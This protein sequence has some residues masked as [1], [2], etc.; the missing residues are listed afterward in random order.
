MYKLSRAK[1]KY[2]LKSIGIHKK[3]YLYRIYS[4]ISLWAMDSRLED[5][6]SHENL[7]GR[8]YRS[9]FDRLPDETLM[10][11]GDLYY[12]GTLA[13][14]IN[15]TRVALNLIKLAPQNATILEDLINFP[16]RILRGL[17]DYKIANPDSKIEALVRKAIDVLV[18]VYSSDEN[19]LGK[20][21]ALES[22]IH[23]SYRDNQYEFLS[24]DINQKEDVTTWRSSSP[25]RSEMSAKLLAE[26]QDMGDILFIPLGHGGVSPGLDVYLRYVDITKS[27]DSIF[28][29]TRFSVH[30]H[31]DTAPKISFSE[32]LFLEEKAK[33][34]NVVVFDEDSSGNTLGEA[35]Q[36]FD[37]SLGYL[38]GK[39]I[40]GLSNQNCRYKGNFVFK[41]RGDPPALLPRRIDG[42]EYRDCFYNA[43]PVSGV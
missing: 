31:R 6:I 27:K 9:L 19:A 3:S 26:Y 2:T 11:G 20:L 18:S 43:F 17:M 7:G 10:G 41:V 38:A 1:V 36:F 37:C 16:P 40:F 4:K 25:E 15:T 42:K 28:Y 22:A 13:G 33:S 8:T 34:R 23:D 5:N 12:N 24:M 21:S 14:V 39:Y 35:C 29:P 30:K 32:T